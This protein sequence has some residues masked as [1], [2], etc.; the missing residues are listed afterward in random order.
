MANKNSKK[1]NGIALTK[2]IIV[3]VDENEI[4]N[5]AKGHLNGAVTS[6]SLVKSPDSKRLNLK[7][8]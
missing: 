8:P 4:L 5:N 7:S 1:K 2:Q 6:G 3:I